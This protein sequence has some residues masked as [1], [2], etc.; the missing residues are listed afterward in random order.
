LSFIGYVHIPT[1]YKKGIILGYKRSLR[2]QN[3]SYVRIKIAEN[4]KELNLKR[5]I[6]KRIFYFMVTKNLKK[7]KIKWG[8]IISLHGK[9]GVVLAKFKSNVPPVMIT[10]S[11]F[12][13]FLP[14]VEK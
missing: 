10:S 14:Y 1:L 12:I 5:L 4:L 9:S 7:N 6:G 2:H 13:T 8:Q 11:V 3:T